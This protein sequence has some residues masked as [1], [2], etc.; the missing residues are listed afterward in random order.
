MTAWREEHI[1]CHWHRWIPEAF[2][3]TIKSMLEKPLNYEWSVQGFGMLRTYLDD[4]KRFRLNIWHS[5]FTIP[6][7][8]IIHDHPWSFDSWIVNGRFTNVRY[9]ISDAPRAGDALYDWQVIKTGPGGGPEGDSGTIR[10]I[11]RASAEHYVTGDTYHQEA[12]EIHAS[13]YDDGTVTL[14]DRTRLPDGDHARVFWPSGGQ[15]VDAE[16][17]PA[18]ATEITFATT[19]ALG[20]WE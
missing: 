10:L 11:S 15:W 13:Y 20:I 1:P 6:N 16:P 12:S 9:G 8:S 5:A 7:V 2:R 3:A 18:R 4:D 19:A 17:R 14:N